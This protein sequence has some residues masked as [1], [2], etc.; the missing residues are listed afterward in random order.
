MNT[1]EKKKFTHANTQDEQTIV[2]AT[3][4]VCDNVQI[5]FISALHFQSQ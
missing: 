1:R 4:V 5:D 2:I 3:A